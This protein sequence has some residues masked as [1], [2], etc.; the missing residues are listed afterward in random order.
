MV[1]ADLADWVLAYC[2]PP[3]EKKDVARASFD[4]DFE[5]LEAGFAA[6]F[7]VVLLGSIAAAPIAVAPSVV[8]VVLNAAAAVQSAPADERAGVAALRGAFA[9]LAAHLR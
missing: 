7:G 8:A 6:A 5:E 9:F 3:T 2:K 1:A 4:A